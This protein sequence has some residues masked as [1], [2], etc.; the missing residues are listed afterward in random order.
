MTQISSV[1]NTP[2]ATQAPKKNPTCIP[3]FTGQT[4]PC[5]VYLVLYMS[6][7]EFYQPLYLNTSLRECF[8]NANENFLQD[9]ERPEFIVASN[10]KDGLKRFADLGLGYFTIGHSSFTTFGRTDPSEA[11]AFAEALRA[12]YVI[13]IEKNLGLQEDAERRKRMRISQEVIFFIESYPSLD[14]KCTKLKQE[15]NN[16]QKSK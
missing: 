3:D 7:V 16:A 14:E 11:I 13:Y 8:I 6:F 10:L 4:N 1:S 5:K 15:F 12:K 2:N 9:G